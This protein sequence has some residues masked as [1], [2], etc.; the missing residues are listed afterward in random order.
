MELKHKNHEHLYST[1]I[2]LANFEVIK[3]IGR[4]SYAKVYLIQQLKTGATE[5]DFY[6]LKVLRKKQIHERGNIKR[7][8]QERKILLEIKH[9]FLV[10]MHYAF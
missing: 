4:G 9:P 2:D 7:V 8:M 6:A 10:H 5:A 3:V 1:D